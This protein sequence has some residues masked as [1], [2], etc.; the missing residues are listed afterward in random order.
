MGLD[1]KFD[2]NELTI[3]GEIPGMMGGSTPIYSTPIPH[4]ENTLRL[5]EGK[6][7][8]VGTVLKRRNKL[9]HGTV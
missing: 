6:N 8:Y 3:K 9:F 7:T 5:Y 2:M 4:K 1:A